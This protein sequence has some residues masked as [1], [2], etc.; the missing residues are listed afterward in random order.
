MPFALTTVSKHGVTLVYAP[1][2]NPVIADAAS[3][4]CFLLQNSIARKEKV[5]WFPAV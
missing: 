3:N 5:L 2:A 4:L 1:V